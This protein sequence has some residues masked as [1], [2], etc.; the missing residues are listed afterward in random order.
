[1]QKSLG[2]LLGIYRSAPLPLVGQTH[3]VNGLGGQQLR[4]ADQQKVALMQ[5]FIEVVGDERRRL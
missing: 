4:R 5:W 1:L 2:S 3:L